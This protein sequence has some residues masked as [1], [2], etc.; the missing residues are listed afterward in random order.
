MFLCCLL[1]LQIPET[2]CAQYP[3]RSNKD[4][5]KDKPQFSTVFYL[6]LTYFQTIPRS[7]F[8]LFMPKFLSFSLFIEG[9]CNIFP[10]GVWELFMIV[11]ILGEL[12]FL[13]F[14]FK[15]VS[16]TLTRLRR[17]SRHRQWFLW[18]LLS[19]LRT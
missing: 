5:H 1:C 3:R 18:C 6:S 11:V 2:S 8:S 12:G 15:L 16:V 9:L 14:L 10:S 4:L 19:H 17:C 13:L 7:S